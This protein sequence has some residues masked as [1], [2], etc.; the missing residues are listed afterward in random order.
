[1][2][3]ILF[4]I[5]ANILFLVSCSILPQPD[6]PEISYYRIQT[7]TTTSA[8][9]QCDESIAIITFDI[10]SLYSR[11]SLVYTENNQAGFYLNDQWMSPPEQLVTDALMDYLTEWDYFSA[12]L[13]A[14]SVTRP[15]Y[16]LAGT[17][18]TLGEHRIGTQSFACVSL[19]VVIADQS[20]SRR[21]SQREKLSQK[22]YSHETPIVQRN[23]KSLVTGLNTSLAKVFKELREDIYATVKKS[24]KAD[25]ASM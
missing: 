16:T 13:T 21:P 3:K 9:T 7:P 20:Y 14:G 5:S 18:E 23:A 1:M 15:Q 4:I 2:R 17:I 11:N 10:A 12:I 8:P 6:A 25:N 19:R 24:E 22:V